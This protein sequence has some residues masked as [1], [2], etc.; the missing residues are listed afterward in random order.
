MTRATAV[1]RYLPCV[2]DGSGVQI[3]SVRRMTDEPVKLRR[4]ETTDLDA[5]LALENSCFRTGPYRTHRFGAT[6]FLSYLNNPR[7]VIFLARDA[8]GLLGSVIATAGTRSR[9]HIGRILN[10]A[11][12]SARR[13]QGVGRQLLEKATQWLR[14]K[15]CDRIF[16]E[17]ALRANAA[18]DFFAGAGFLPVRRL[19]EYYGP[20]NHGLRMMRKLR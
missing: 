3:A 8:S 12:V 2:V 7:A 20:N 1:S 13:Q 15:G 16:L 6:Q 10:L 18:H 4:A 5:L 17:V 9:A 19:P 11:V 14:Q